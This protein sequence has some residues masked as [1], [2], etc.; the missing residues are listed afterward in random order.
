MCPLPPIGGSGYLGVQEEEDA[1]DEVPP[2]LPL[3]PPPS[4]D[5][6]ETVET[7]ET[8]DNC[9]QPSISLS[10]CNPELNETSEA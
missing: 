6:V 5:L 7:G 9:T 4:V 2:P 3:N 1:S 8:T 10:L